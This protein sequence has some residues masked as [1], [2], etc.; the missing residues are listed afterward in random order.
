M[1][2]KSNLWC[3]N[4]KSMKQCIV[5]LSN[6]PSILGVNALPFGG[7][8]SVAGFLRVSHALW[9]IGAVALGLCWTAFYDDFSVLSREELLRST[10]SSCEL[11][12]RLLGID[13]ADTGKEAVPFSQNF[14]M[15]GLVVN[16]E[17]STSASLSISHTEERRQEL[18]ASLQSILD[19]GSLTPKEAEKL[20]GRM[21]FFEGYTFG[22][23]A[24]AAVKNLGRLSMNQT[25][26]NVL[27]NEL[28]STL[29]FLMFR[30]Q[31][32]E[33]VKVEKCFSS[34]WLVFTD[35]CCEADKRFG[36]IGGIL[37]SP[38]G[39]CVSFFSSAVPSWMMDKL[40]VKSANPIHELEILPVHGGDISTS[41][42]WYGT[43]TMS[44]QGWLSFVVQV[45]RNMHQYSLKPLYKLNATLRLNHGSH[46][47]RLIQIQ[48][49]VY[50]VCHAIFPFH[51][52]RNKPRLSGRVAGASWIRGERF[53]RLRMTPQLLEEKELSAQ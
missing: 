9:H 13:Y 50:L 44:R 33:P 17:S 26:N 6:N 22:R 47:C 2:R 41:L 53:G 18:V 28:A 49:M 10:S 3:P 7:V 48:L 14:K 21:V 39:S 27:N 19:N 30:V 34:T 23:I 51:L 12:F 45:K 15:L 29:R 8:G 1:A 31:S 16:T 11:L 20:R 43:L 46:V 40:L 42:K 5:I 38:Q 36:G 37:I 52:V 24:N 4:F 25:A 35:G 32:A